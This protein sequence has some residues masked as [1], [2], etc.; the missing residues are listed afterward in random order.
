MSERAGSLDGMSAKQKEALFD[1]PRRREV[2]PEPFAEWRAYAFNLET[3]IAE[4][5]DQIRSLNELR[6]S[7]GNRQDRKR[8]AG[9]ERSLGQAQYTI[10]RLKEGIEALT[11]A[12]GDDTI[13]E[14]DPDG[15]VLAIPTKEG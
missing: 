4:Q 12:K 3:V 13:Y 2:P 5:R 6:G 8:I 9:L 15:R 1:G 11:R 14:F 10:D 7:D